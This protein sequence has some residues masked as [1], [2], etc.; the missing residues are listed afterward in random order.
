MFWELPLGL[1]SERHSDLLIQITKKQ[2][3]EIATPVQYPPF[4]AVSA[5]SAITL[6][7]CGQ[8]QDSGEA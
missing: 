7:H 4:S 6:G 8:T 2:I 5:L 1:A 3:H